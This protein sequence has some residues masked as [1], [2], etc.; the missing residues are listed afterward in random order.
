MFGAWRVHA[1]IELDQ[2]MALDQDGDLVGRSLNGLNH[3]HPEG[4]TVSP[5]YVFSD[6][7][8][9]RF[10]QSRLEP[11]RSIVFPFNREWQGKGLQE[12]MLEGMFGDVREQA[13]TKRFRN[14]SRSSLHG[15]RFVP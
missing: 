12:T 2:R 3:T 13:S 14:P 4:S 8:R 11:P 9:W 7:E 15:T 1:K 5:N 6:K 10:D